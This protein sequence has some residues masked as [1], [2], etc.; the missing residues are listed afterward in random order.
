MAAGQTVTFQVTVPDAG[1]VLFTEDGLPKIEVVNSTDN[2]GNNVT[3]GFLRFNVAPNASGSVQVTV[4]AVDSVGT[5]ATP[6]TFTISV[7]EVN[8][9]PV[10][11]NDTFSGDEDT[12]FAFTPAQLLANDTDADTQFNPNEV[13]TIVGLPSTSLNG[14][15]I[16]VLDDGSF[17]YD[18]SVSP[19]LQALPPGQTRA[20]TFTYRVQDVAG[21]Q[22]NLATVTVN[23]A[24][25]NDAPV[26]LPDT[27]T[28]APTGVTTI[29]PLLNDSDIDGTIDPTSL[30]IT[31]QPSFGSL[32]V[33]ADGTLIYTPFS[34]FRGSDV[35]RYTVAD[36]LGLRSEEQTIT[37]DVNQAPV[38]VNDRSGSFRDKSIDINVASNDSDPDGT[39][40][41]ESVVITRAPA[42]GTALSIG[43][44]LVRYVPEA[45]FIGSDS[46]QYTIQ[47]AKGRES[48]V[49]TVT[50]QVVGSTLQNPVNSTDVNSSGQTSPLDALLVINR[51]A[52]ARRD[53]VTGPIVV[54]PTDQ[55]PNYFDVDGNGVITPND[56]L[57]VINQIAR[58]NSTRLTTGGGEGELV[59]TA[60][61][62]FAAAN[63]NAVAGNQSVT[64]NDLAVADFA[65]NTLVADFSIPV[66]NAVST[67]AGTYDAEQKKT[68]VKHEAAVDAAWADAADF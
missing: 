44:G 67:L 26:L 42:R 63:S 21:R 60:A 66:N 59:A 35:I 1:K 9:V 48:N 23:V 13:L 14:A 25:R 43:G 24:G 50:L 33:K 45:G 57:R 12:A 17:E 30:T 56:A 10:A 47:D 2:N 28:L 39:L 52:R 27:P 54:S 31:L 16:R 68:A 36:N 49:A 32:E 61:P 62:Q 20:D 40:D 7:N 41:L 6:V 64:V 51:I 38:A 53:G 4:V 8:D 46:F 11:N 34:G 29:R 37:I 65:A 19:A 55:G 5:S 3:S 15:A 22:S 18:P 58:D